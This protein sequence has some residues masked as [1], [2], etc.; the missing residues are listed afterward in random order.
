MMTFGKHWI[1]L[2]LGLVWTV[3]PA[4]A[5]E[6]GDSTKRTGFDYSVRLGTFLDNGEYNSDY[7]MPQTMSAAWIT[8]TVGLRFEGRHR[9]MTGVSGL[10]EFGQKP[11][12]K[13][14]DLVAY[15][16]YQ[17]QVFTAF[18]GLF[19]REELK[20]D[21]PRAFFSDSVGYFK[22]TLAGALFRW[23]GKRGMLETFLDWNIQ[24]TVQG[25][26]A[27]MV[28][29]SGHL[30]WGKYNQFQLGLVGTYYHYRLG[31]RAVDNGLAPHFLVDN[32]MYQAYGKFDFG[33]MTPLD[34]LSLDMGIV[35]SFSRGRPAVGHAG[36]W[37]ARAGFQA[38]LHV[39]W[40]G[41]GL[42]DTFFAGR[43][44]MP[45]WNTYGTLVYWGDAFYNAPLYN[46]TDIYWSKTLASLLD[47]RLALVLHQTAQG[48]DFCQ[49]ATV[50]VHLWK[51]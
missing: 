27:F 15:Y 2:A 14:P 38:R 22:R 6:T 11:F 41:W 5:A 33:K 39:K 1:G 26:E 13:V 10:Q 30:Q 19:P 20:G 43:G 49:Q 48:V 7:K 34:T 45:L 9:I 40:R 3:C 51:K 36:K 18:A 23:E 8:P 12:N 42:E 31:Q 32:A 37:T 17:G 25:K 29:V 4:R 28:G 16:N 24:D 47:I 44:L 50:Q 46:R 21:Y 35:G